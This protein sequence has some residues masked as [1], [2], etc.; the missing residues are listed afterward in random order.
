[1]ENELHFSLLT[2]EI[3]LFHAFYDA[4]FKGRNDRP[5]MRKCQDI[6]EKQPTRPVL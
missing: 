5:K 4:V 1:M 6:H 3:E 2:T